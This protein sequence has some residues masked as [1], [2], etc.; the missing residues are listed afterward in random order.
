MTDVALV[1]KVADLLRELAMQEPTGATTSELARDGGLSRSTAH[2][3]LATLH[4]RGL[5]DRHADS[6]HWVLGPEAFL[7]GTV[8]APRYD[9]RSLAGPVVRRLAD[10]TGESAPNSRCVAAAAGSNRGR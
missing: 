1:V 6:G 7:L 10:E 2:R 3:I 9:L 4:T 8:C 5:V